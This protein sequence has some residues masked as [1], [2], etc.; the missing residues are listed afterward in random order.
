LY[1]V[2]RPCTTAIASGGKKSSYN[3]SVYASP[4]NGGSGYEK[5]QSGYALCAVLSP[6]DFGH[7]QT[8]KP[9]K[10]RFLAFGLL[11]WCPKPRKQPERYVTFWLKLVGK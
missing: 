10:N 9:G 2:V 3:R 4:P 1:A 8:K 7:L 11:I 5:P 6:P